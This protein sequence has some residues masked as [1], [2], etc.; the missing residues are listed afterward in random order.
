MC[1]RLSGPNALPNNKWCTKADEQSKTKNKLNK[2]KITQKRNRNRNRCK[3][4]NHLHLWFEK[5]DHHYFVIN[6]FGVSLHFHFSLLFAAFLRLFN[7]SGWCTISN[8]HLG[9]WTQSIAQTCSSVEINREKK[10]D[11]TKPGNRLK[12]Q[13]FSWLHAYSISCTCRWDEN[14]RVKER[15]QQREKWMF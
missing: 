4:L 6:M 13:F 8:Q 2:K 15:R 11:A 1:C 3:V 9:N 10:K 12:I 5:N 14:R 7:M